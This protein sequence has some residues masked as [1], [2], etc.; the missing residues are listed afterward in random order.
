MASARQLQQQL[1]W[2]SCGRSYAPASL[3]NTGTCLTLSALPL[4]K[5]L[6][7]REMLLIQSCKFLDS[8]VK[9]N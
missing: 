5:E 7:A 3:Y 9:E 6:K 2:R 8:K 1:A 4:A